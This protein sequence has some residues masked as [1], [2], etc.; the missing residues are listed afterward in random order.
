[1]ISKLVSEL[2]TAAELANLLPVPSAFLHEPLVIKEAKA[3]PP[4]AGK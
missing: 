2:H 3:A 4:P 1:M